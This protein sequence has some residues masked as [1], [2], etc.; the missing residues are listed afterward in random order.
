M[1]EPT[2]VPPAGASAGSDPRSVGELVSDVA[3]DITTLMRQELRLARAETKQE[4]RRS[5]TAAG[6]AGLAAVAG[7][8]M[9]ALVSWAGVAA[10]D[11]VMETAPAHLVV[12]GVWL[13]VAVVA[14]LMARRT[15]QSID[16][17]PSRTTETLRE[18]PDALRGATR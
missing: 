9:L 6:L 15:V 3:E 2:R 13:I 8:L 10:L 16:P 14:G 12:A 4:V 1:P 5:A 11:E 7:V 17:V 18:I